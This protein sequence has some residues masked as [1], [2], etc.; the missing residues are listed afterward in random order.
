MNRDVVVIGGSA[1]GIE[2]LVDLVSALPA[3]LRAAIFVV[4]HR[5]PNGT[6]LLPEILSRRGALP[7]RH[8]L[9]DERTAPGSIYIAP[10]DNQLL[11]RPGS[12]KVVAGPREDAHRPAADALSR[13]ASAATGPRVYGVVLTGDQECGKAATRSTKTR[14]G[15]SVVQSPQSAQAPHMP[16]SVLERVDV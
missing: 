5:A 1:G 11:L 9:H 14:G 2:V 8:P 7:A 4:V 10:P 15:A 13:T 3:D 16:Q 6:D 12:V